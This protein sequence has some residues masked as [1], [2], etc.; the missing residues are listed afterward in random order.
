M[1]DAVNWEH[2]LVTGNG[3]Q[4]ALCWGGREA[5][6]LTVSHERLFLPV[7][8]R[9]DAPDTAAILPRLRGLLAAGRYAAAAEAVCA[10]AAAAEPAYAETVWIDPLVGAA[11]LTVRPERPG[12]SS[13]SVELGSG[14]VEYRWAGGHLRV[15]ASRASDA[16]LVALSAPGGFRGTLDLSLIESTPPI[17]V[18]GRVATGPTLNVDFG[19]APG[20]RVRCR[21]LSGDVDGCEVRSDAVLAIRTLL[22]GDADPAV[23]DEDFEALLA[24]HRDLHGELM[25]RVRLD[26]GASRAARAAPTARLLAAPVGPALVERLFDA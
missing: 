8:P 16:I 23:P 15:F 2:A 4:G 18:T 17:P 5:I 10:H 11:T 20:Y 14:L 21:V 7:G 26:L 3:R 13:W 25:G 9:L 1:R 24:A 22:P 19:A 6:R 12:A